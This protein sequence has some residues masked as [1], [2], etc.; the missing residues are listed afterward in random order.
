MG[1][2]IG[3][4]STGRDEAARELLR[5]VVEGIASGELPLEIAFV[6]CNREEGEDPESDAFIRQVRDYRLSLV[7]FS[8]ARFKP[9]LRRR[10]LAGDPEA[11]A[12]WRTDYHA[13]ASEKLSSFSVNFSFLA[14]YMLIVSAAMCSRHAMLNLHP[15]LPGGPKGTWQEV[16]W[17]LIAARAG[18]AGAM[19]HLVT[20]ELDA[21]PPVTFCRFL[22][23]TPAMEPLW[24]ELEEKLQQKSL[25]QLQTEEGEENR[26]FQEIR[27]QEFARELPLIWLTLA[28]LAH[29]EIRIEDR[30][31]FH[32]GEPSPG[33]DV[34]RDVD[35]LLDRFPVN[36]EHEV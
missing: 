31:V 27:R 29:G 2:R 20:P 3:W 7:S 23:R 12:R 9:D 6:F 21:G 32:G 35:R 36:Q 16:I 13:A 8:S 19:I 10:G 30:R 24:A 33:V 1:L 34:S 18:E 4:F 11:L 25:A 15:A 22:L 26:L 5:I 14:G 17:Q 28:K